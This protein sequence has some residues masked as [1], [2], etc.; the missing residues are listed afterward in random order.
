M[1]SSAGKTVSKL[2]SG[3]YRFTIS[4]HDPK[5]GFIVL[6]PTSTAPKSLTVAGFTGTRSV[7]LSLTAGKWSYYASLATVHFFR[8]T[9]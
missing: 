9:D 8:V 6:G 2:A 7:T 3:R 4:D 1:L 5:A